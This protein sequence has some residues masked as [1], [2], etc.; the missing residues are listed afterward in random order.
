[1]QSRRAFVPLVVL[2]VVG[3]G[4]THFAYEI[5]G[6]FLALI[7]YAVGAGLALESGAG[8]G[9]SNGVVIVSVTVVG[10]VLGRLV[11]PALSRLAVGVLGFVTTALSA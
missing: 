4:L 11:V 6:G 1:M 5:S 3:V 8:V 7:G 10:A 9:G 2:A